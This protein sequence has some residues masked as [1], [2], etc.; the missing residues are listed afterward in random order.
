MKAWGPLYSGL[1]PIKE[2]FREGNVSGSNSPSRS[3]ENEEH[4]IRSQQ[5]FGLPDKTPQ[6]N[7]ELPALQQKMSEDIEVEE[8]KMF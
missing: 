6:F 3:N 7:S 5:L 4:Q 2:M 8:G 1:K